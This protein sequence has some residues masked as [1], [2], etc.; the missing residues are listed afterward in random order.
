M[1]RSTFISILL[2][3]GIIALILSINFLSHHKQKNAIQ[4]A[5]KQQSIQA[6][7]IYYDEQI[8][9]ASTLYIASPQVKE[10]IKQESTPIAIPKKTSIHTTTKLLLPEPI[11][12]SPIK[13]PTQD[14]TT[15][16]ILMAKPHSSVHINSSTHEINIAL[17]QLQN[18]LS[19]L[20]TE[21]ATPQTS[22]NF[23]ILLSLTPT[24]D[25]AWLKFSPTPPQAI[26]M[27]LTTFLQQQSYTRQLRFAQQVNITIPVKLVK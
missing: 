10:Q 2:H 20:L 6:Q 16:K 12:P 21:Q 3:F 23:N 26:Q 13:K 1:K 27:A 7:L 14:N 15:N 24:G 9:N 19:T 25:I 4:L 8:N 5:P 17:D 11:Q 22:I 18:A